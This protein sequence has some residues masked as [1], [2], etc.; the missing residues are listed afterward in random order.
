M[1]TVNLCDLC[2][3]NYGECMN[4]HENIPEVKYG[5]DG[6]HNDAILECDWFMYKPKRE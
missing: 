1:S 4:D 5:N 6:E 3:R 2:V